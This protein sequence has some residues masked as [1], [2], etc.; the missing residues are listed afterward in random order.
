MRRTTS[1]DAN[2]NPK[3]MDNYMAPQRLRDVVGTRK[4]TYIGKDDI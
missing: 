2:R 3:Y 4:S 1:D